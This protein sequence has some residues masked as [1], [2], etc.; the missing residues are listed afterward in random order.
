MGDDGFGCDDRAVADGDA[1]QD[2]GFHADPHIVAEHGVAAIFRLPA[3]H[4]EAFLP[5]MAEDVERVGGEARHGVVGPVHDEARAFGDGAEAADDQ[6]VADERVVVQ[7]ALFGEPVRAV[8]VVVIG[9]V[10]DLDVLGRDE[11]F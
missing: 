5:A 2:H 6:P 8:G 11:R 9:V 4:V 7:H 10:A 1:R 3:L